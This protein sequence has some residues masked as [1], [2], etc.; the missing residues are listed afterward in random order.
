MR[1][2]SL[3]EHAIAITLMAGF[4]SPSVGVADN[5]AK[6]QPACRF[7]TVAVFDGP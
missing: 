7:E 3:R 2:I 4:A 6:D 5:I 1:F